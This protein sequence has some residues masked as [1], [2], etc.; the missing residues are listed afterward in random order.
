MLIAVLSDIHGNREAFDACIGKA[1]AMGAERLVFLGDLVG[2]GGDP[3]YIVDAVAA[4][5]AKGAISLL[6]NHDAAI[7]AGATQH[8][9]TYARAA[10]EWTA[11]QLD[12][13][14]TAFLAAMPLSATLEETLFV[15]A[16][17]SAPGRFI[18]VASAREAERSLNATT[19][20][21]TF[22]GHVHKPRLYHMAPDKPPAPFAPV[23][24]IATPL[25]R[26]RQWL[27]VAGSVGQPRDE[28]PQTGFCLY[29]SARAVVTFVRLG[30]DIEAA[31]RKIKQA[32]LP[33]MLSAR[34]FIG[35]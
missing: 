30:Y 3:A 25:A 33:L 31:A 26:S 14:Q 19:A 5:C 13:A 15:H 17:A 12:S 1:R 21:L 6:G 16:D 24:N 22:C 10:I 29:D 7:H 28:N 23:A 8:M 18:Y 27:A 20:R 11:R 9:N 2:Y 35:R 34:L 4:E 32:G